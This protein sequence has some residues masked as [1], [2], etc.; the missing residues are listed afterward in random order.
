ML[1]E[2]AEALIAERRRFKIHPTGRRIEIAPPAMIFFGMTI[3]L[4][5]YD[6]FASAP[7]DI[8][9]AADCAQPRIDPV[10]GTLSK[11]RMDVCK[12]GCLGAGCAISCGG[13]TVH[14]NLLLSR[15]L[16]LPEVV[17]DDIDYMDALGRRALGTFSVPFD[18]ARA[19]VDRA[20]CSIT[21]RIL[22]HQVPRLS[23]VLVGRQGTGEPCIASWAETDGFKCQETR[24][25]K[26]L[27]IPP[28]EL[29]PDQVKELVARVTCGSP[30][31][32]VQAA[33]SYCASVA[34]ICVSSQFSYARLV[35]QFEIRH[36]SPR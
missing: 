35:E 32:R 7:N 5:L 4:A 23:V 34:P 16:G 30:F 25:G 36:A 13:A 14:Q 28:S 21:E 19:M 11:G 33:V 17:G 2:A 3:Q 29:T 1:S 26:D 22:S 12:L 20:F 27:L 9:I 6:A 15:L 8:L 10:D 18:A 31:Q 24:P